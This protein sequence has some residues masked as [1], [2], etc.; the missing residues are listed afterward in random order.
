MSVAGRTTTRVG[1]LNGTVIVDDDVGGDASIAAALK[2]DRQKDS[3]KYFLVMGK[4]I[5]ERSSNILTRLDLA[6]V[7]V[8]AAARDE[9]RTK[10]M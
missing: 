7:V 2:N 4:K 6:R 5:N 1:E 10:V 3:I 8:R 9:P